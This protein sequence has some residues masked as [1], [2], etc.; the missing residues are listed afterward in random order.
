MS[1]KIERQSSLI[2]HTFICIV[3]Q[4][5]ISPTQNLIFVN[6]VLT[7]IYR[8]EKRYTSLAQ[9]KR[10][11]GRRASLGAVDKE[12]S[13]KKNF[14][15]HPLTFLFFFWGGYQY[16]PLSIIVLAASWRKS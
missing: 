11:P 3:S 5:T 6:Q 12:V 7:F 1:S 14:L 15:H 2:F 9:Y 13:K 8:S 16:H 10:L 4:K